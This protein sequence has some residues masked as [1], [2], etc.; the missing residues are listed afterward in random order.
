MPVFFSFNRYLQI[1][2]LAIILVHHLRK[3]D[4]SDDFNKILGTAGIMGSSDTTF[5]LEKKSRDDSVATLFVTGWD[6]ADVLG[7]KDIQT[8]ENYYI[9]STY[10]TRKNA[11]DSYENA[12]NLDV[13]EDIIKYEIG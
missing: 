11:A 7:H 12:I 13:I 8:T 5:I 10:E 3:Q 9:S 6:V 2:K 1:K 4:D